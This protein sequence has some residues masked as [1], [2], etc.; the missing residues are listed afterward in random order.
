[1]NFRVTFLRRSLV[2]FGLLLGLAALLSATGTRSEA[3]TISLSS[4]FGPSVVRVEEDWSLLVSQPNKD[5]ASPQV[6]TQMARSPYSSRFCNFHLNS[7]DVPAFAL[8]GFQLQ[9]WKGSTNLPYMNSSTSPILSTDNELITWTQYL[10]QNS[11]VKLTFGISA[12]S[13]QTF[14]DFSGVSID[15]PSGSTSLDNYSPD[16]SLA[17]SGVTYGANRVTSLVIVQ[18]RKIYSDGSVVSDSTPRVV[19]SSVLD[20]DLSGNSGN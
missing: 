12:A 1:M 5:S 18:V 10:K 7:T 9:V 4:L 16:Y 6:S 17:N 3:Q 8:G 14:G 2:V 15:I 13:S 19:Y 20:P 11:N